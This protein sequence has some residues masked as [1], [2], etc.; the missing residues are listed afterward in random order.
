MN[1]LDLSR[2]ECIIEEIF[3]ICSFYLEHTFKAM[4]CMSAKGSNSLTVCYNQMKSLF[5]DSYYNRLYY[6]W[7]VKGDPAELCQMSHKFVGFT[8]E[9]NNMM[10]CLRIIIREKP[11]TCLSV[12]VWAACELLYSQAQAANLPRKYIV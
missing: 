9:Q 2:K 10:I 1:V 7:S 11:K 4:L 12:C 8:R 6:W 5:L 3:L